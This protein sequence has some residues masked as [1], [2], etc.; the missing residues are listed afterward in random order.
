MTVIKPNKR[1]LS[2]FAGRIGAAWDALRGIEQQVDFG[3][4]VPLMPAKTGEV[5]PRGF[6]YPVSVN[7]N[8]SPRS[9]YPAAT[10]TP[11][12][13]LRNLASLYDVAAICIATFI[14][15]MQRKR[16]VIMPRDKKRGGELA[17]K[18][19]EM[20][21]FFRK[22]DG[23]EPYQMWL[24]DVL[25]DVLS[26]DALTVFKRKNRA[27]GLHGLEVVD[28]STIKPL[29]DTRGSVAGYQQVVY[30]RVEGD[31]ST[32]EMLY[33][34]RWTR[35]FT[36]YGFPPTEWIV[37]RVNTALRK[38]TLDLGHFT[39]GNIPPMLV[40]APDGVLSPQQV[41][42]FEQVFNAV[43]EGNDGARNRVKFMPWQAQVKE[44]KPFSY[45]TQLDKFMMQ[46][47]CAAYGRMPQ[48]LGFIEDVNRSNGEVQNDITEL[49]EEGLANW[50]KSAI[51]DPILAHDLNAPEL[52]WVWVKDRL[53]EDRLTEAQ[54][55]QIDIGAGVITPQESRAMRYAD[56]LKAE[57]APPTPPEEQKLQKG[58]TGRSADDKEAQEVFSRAY[59]E[60]HQRVQKALKAGEGSDLMVILANEFANEPN[61]VAQAV[62]GFYEKVAVAVALETMEQI[63]A[64]DWDLVNAEALA[65]A[66]ANAMS[67]AKEMSLTSQAQ[68]AKIIE[69]WVETGGTMPELMERIGK[70]WTGPRPDVAAV[71]EITKLYSKAQQVAWKESGVVKEWEWAT[72]G[73]E[74]TCPICRPLNGKRYPIDDEV[75]LPPAHPRCRCDISP[76]IEGDE[77]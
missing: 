41:I 5:E 58:L 32:E 36:P 45:D 33:R 2:T 57:D 67:F 26:I 29:I 35:R 3:P 74:L 28:G 43:L 77:P 69:N 14:E 51:F 72:V 7:T 34:P 25:Y 63:P 9:E 48:A 75:H 16:W 38:Q 62:A 44:L 64:V 17:G 71:T 66:Q 53:I 42:E 54:I 50:L 12:E 23:K 52:E 47:T 1:D 76:I 11:F 27:G 55:H 56:E 40:S 70:V 60:Q 61:N 22:P 19:A 20:T 4:G 73:D 30:G 6:Q 39:D 68:A 37:M 24:G 18:I 13:Q 15:E 10:L 8:I 65:M 46:I 21:D 31:Y 59:L 49:R